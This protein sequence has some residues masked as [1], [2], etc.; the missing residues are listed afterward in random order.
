MKI[1]KFVPKKIVLG[2]K[3]ARQ[4]RINSYKKTGGQILS[5]K[6][7]GTAVTVAW[8]MIRKGIKPNFKKLAEKISKAKKQDS[9][10]SP[11]L[12]SICRETGIFETKEWKKITGKPKKKT[13]KTKKGTGKTKTKKNGIF[14][15]EMKKSNFI[16]MLPK[17]MQP[18]IKTAVYF[19]FMENLFRLGKQTETKVFTAKEV[20][21]KATE[22]WQNRKINEL[23]KELGLETKTKFKYQNPFD[24][25]KIIGTEAQK[26]GAKLIQTKTSWKIVYPETTA[27][28]VNQQHVTATKKMPEKMIELLTRIHSESGNGKM[29]GVYITAGHELYSNK[30]RLDSAVLES[31]STK[32]NRLN[33]KISPAFLRELAVKMK[34][35]K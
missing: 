8:S 21:N 29:L 19:L 2:A 26:N 5:D 30:T 3:Q 4:K 34:L 7:I 15:P 11:S 6:S 28:A 31:I 33:A 22:L 24:S 13:Q 1:A 23:K 27:K 20:A 9:I 25:K 17:N 12:I 16:A 10:S 32:L 18:K 35:I 14:P